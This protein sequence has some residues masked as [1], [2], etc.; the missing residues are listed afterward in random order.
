MRHNPRSQGDRGTLLDRLD[1]PDGQRV[2]GHPGHERRV[3]RRG[4]GLQATD[5]DAEYYRV[6]FKGLAEMLKGN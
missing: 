6:T 2:V 3:R 5:S 4:T 1:I